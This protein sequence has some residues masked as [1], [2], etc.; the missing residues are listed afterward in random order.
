MTEPTEADELAFAIRDV[1]ELRVGISTQLGRVLGAARREL[2]RMREP[3]RAPPLDAIAKVRAF[4][5]Y[6]EERAGNGKDFFDK[7]DH[8]AMA[9]LPEIE[10]FVK[11]AST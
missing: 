2:A 5:E 7:G 10:A 9:A 6:R 11:A 4:M 3:R 8:D 1:S